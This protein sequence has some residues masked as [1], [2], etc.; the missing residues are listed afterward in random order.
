MITKKLKIPFYV[1]RGY[2][3]KSGEELLDLWETV[4]KEFSQNDDHN[5]LSASFPFFNLLLICLLFV[6]VFYASR[7][8]L[9]YF[10][11]L[12]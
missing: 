12:F 10:F 5:L 3:P 8:L 9:V 11:H 6:V 4:E 2:R 1:E 7:R